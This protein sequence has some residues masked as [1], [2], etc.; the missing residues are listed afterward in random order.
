MSG[1]MGEILNSS[2][3]LSNQSASLSVIS[4]NISNVNNSSYARETLE[5]SSYSG[6]GGAV[7]TESTI[8]SARDAILDRQVV[9]ETSTSS[10]LSTN[11][12]LYTSLNNVM[13][14]SL[15][16][17]IGASLATAESDG[18]G[19]TGGIST[20]LNDWSAYAASPNSSSAQDQ[21]YSSSEELVDRLH[22]ASAELDQVQSDQNAALDEDVSSAN[23]LLSKIAALN[24]QIVSANARN[25]GS[26]VTLSD[27]RESAM[28]DLA[29]LTSFD[30]TT[31]S[32]GSITISVASGDNST[33]TT[34]LVSGGKAG[35]IGI[36]TDSTGA[37]TGLSATSAV[38]GATSSLSPE[39]GSL[40]V[41]DPAVTTSVISGVR[42]QLDALASQII[43]SVNSVY[44]GTSA[45]GSA[46]FF[47]GSTAADISISSSITS[48][49]DITAASS[50]EAAG[51]NSVA[52]AMSN[53]LDTEYATASGDKIDGTMTESAAAI[54]TDI[55][56]KLSKATDASDSQ[57][58]VLSLVTTN[59]D[60]TSGVS[61]DEELSDLI[62]TQHAYQASAR[63]LSTVNTLL[64]IVTTRLGS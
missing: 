32:N 47:S 57:A 27:E 30:Y 36:T 56:D 63:I 59:R 26:S 15:N 19:I 16:G 6:P 5:T 33:G 14:E 4:S 17:S 49:S 21:V 34:T 25:D 1:L 10:A 41:L 18:T 22:S 54:A 58:N 12:S 2:Q 52:L 50:T 44:S 7:Y 37:Y 40:S 43:T 61:T 29:K 45:D 13:S 60:N 11:E 64:E 42:D 38:G 46:T 9:E 62:R 39:G 8:T 24:T 55:A 31:E 28:E 23:T 35:S 20:L 53:L 48:A 51:G 3:S